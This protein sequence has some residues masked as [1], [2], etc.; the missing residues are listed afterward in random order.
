MHFSHCFKGPGRQLLIIGTRSD[1][2]KFFHIYVSTQS[3]YSLQLF[4]LLFQRL[5]QTVPEFVNR[6]L[7]MFISFYP[8]LEKID[9]A[10]RVLFS[11]VR[12]QESPGIA[13]LSSLNSWRRIRCPWRNK[14][15]HSWKSN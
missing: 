7:L 3:L 8:C 10:N 13:L 15:G 14:P 11:F 5:N 4:I 2:T 1:W 12:I 6:V 9:N